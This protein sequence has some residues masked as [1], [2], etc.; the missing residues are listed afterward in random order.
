[1]RQ[2][3][4]GRE[5]TTVWEFSRGKVIKKIVDGKVVESAETTD[6]EVKAEVKA[7]HEYDRNWRPRW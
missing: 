6:E 5:V 3:I 7:K 2:V 4:D 1:M